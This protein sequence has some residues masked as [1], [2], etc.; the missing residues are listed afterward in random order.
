M[1]ISSKHYLSQNIRTTQTAEGVLGNIV[2]PSSRDN[3]LLAF[4]KDEF[5][6]SPAVGQLL[7][8]SYVRDVVSRV[9]QTSPILLIFG[10]SVDKCAFY[11]GVYLDDRVQM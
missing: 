3:G 1:Q 10:P 5:T 11:N 2:I 4:R 8:T 9:S 6:R 7:S